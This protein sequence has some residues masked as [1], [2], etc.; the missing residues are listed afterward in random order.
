MCPHL[1]AFGLNEVFSTGPVSSKLSKHAIAAFP[2]ATIGTSRSGATRFGE[3]ASP[4]PPCL[5]FPA[6]SR[7]C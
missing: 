5:P 2:T 1:S 7:Y 3:R 4:P 6:A